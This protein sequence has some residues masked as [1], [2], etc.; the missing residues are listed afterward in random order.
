MPGL[1]LHD[2]NAYYLRIDDDKDNFAE[3]RRIA[4]ERD[5]GCKLLQVSRFKTAD[6]HLV[7]IFATLRVSFLNRVPP[8][9]DRVLLQKIEAAVVEIN[10]RHA[11]AGQCNLYTLVIEALRA[12][13]IQ[14]VH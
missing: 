12:Q 3:E 10:A 5:P 1:S 8:E 4:R 6:G 2:G 9:V 7:D 14:I 13:G 11:A